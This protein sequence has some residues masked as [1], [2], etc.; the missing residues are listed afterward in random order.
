MCIRDRAHTAVHTSN[1]GGL[2]THHR[3]SSGVSD[4]SVDVSTAGSDPVGGGD[5]GNNPAQTTKKWVARPVWEDFVRLDAFDLQVDSSVDI[6]VLSDDVGAV[7]G[8]KTTVGTA[9]IENLF[10]YNDGRLHTVQTPIVNVGTGG[11]VGVLHLRVRVSAVNPNVVAANKDR[12]PNATL[13]TAPRTY[14]T[15]FALSAADQLGTGLTGMSQAMRRNVTNA[16]AVMP[17]PQKYVDTAAKGMRAAALKALN[18][19]ARQGRWAVRSVYKGC[20]KLVYGQEE[21]RRRKKEKLT[22]ELEAAERAAG[23]AA[24]WKL[25]LIHI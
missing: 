6:K 20:K 15:Q 9:L 21:Y 16:I 8:S 5:T 12:N 17:I 22:R 7:M 19:P 24:A 18:E 2:K 11:V 25:S 4:F 13:L 23:Y 10:D 14:T 3:Q 1:G